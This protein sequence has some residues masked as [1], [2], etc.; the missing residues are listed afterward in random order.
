VK[1]TILVCEGISDLDRLDAVQK[2]ER[3]HENSRDGS[4]VGKDQPGNV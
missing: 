2:C 3:Y 4:I 1:V